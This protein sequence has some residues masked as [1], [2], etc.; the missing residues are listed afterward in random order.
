MFLINVDY[1]S[2]FTLA[3]IA[4]ETSLLLNINSP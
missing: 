1:I 3:T 2:S 4:L